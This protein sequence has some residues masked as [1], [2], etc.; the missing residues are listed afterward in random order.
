MNCT[1]QQAYQLIVDGKI[2][3]TF[4]NYDDLTAFLDYYFDFSIFQTELLIRDK[5]LFFGKN[6][7]CVNE[8]FVPIREDDYQKKRKLSDQ[9][10]ENVTFAY[11]VNVPKINWF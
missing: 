10:L 2:M 5:H 4:H 7:I 6:E 1:N 11:S 3:E 8:C 9:P